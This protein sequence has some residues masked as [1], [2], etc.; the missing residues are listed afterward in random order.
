MEKVARN[1]EPSR[2]IYRMSGRM[3]G[4]GHGLYAK[5]QG[6]GIC[7]AVQAVTV[8]I[9]SLNGLFASVVAHRRPCRI[10]RV[11]DIELCV[12]EQGFAIRLK[13]SDVVAVEVRHEDIVD[14]L[15]GY[16]CGTEPFEHLAAM[17][18]A[19]AR[20]EKNTLALRLDNKA[21]YRRG[22]RSLRREFLNLGRVGLA[23]EEFVGHTLLAVVV[24]EGYEC[25]RIDLACG[26]AF[27]RGLC[28][29]RCSRS[30]CSICAAFG[31]IVT[32]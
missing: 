18:G 30:L 29:C 3:S 32:A 16:A 8:R 9:H 17:C 7:E 6:I 5:R 4:C 24:L 25:Q 15:G 23:V 13:A 1:E 21:A 22:D 26:D 14:L 2:L 20:V 28:G 19:V 11:G 27:G 31:G 10:F 12:C